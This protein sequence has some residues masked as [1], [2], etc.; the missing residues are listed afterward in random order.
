[1]SEGGTVQIIKV[2]I[3]KRGIQQTELTAWVGGRAVVNERGQGISSSRTTRGRYPG[4]RQ[5]TD[6]WGGGKEKFKSS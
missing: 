5:Q 4:R 6:E 2:N 3:L 1:M